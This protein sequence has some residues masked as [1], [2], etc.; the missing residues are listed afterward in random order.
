MNVEPEAKPI[1]CLVWDLD[2][3]VWHGILLEGSVEL[4]PDA[5][6]V[7]RTLDGRGIL[8]AI[9]SRNDHHMAMAQLATFGLA[10][11]F[12]CPQINW[13]AKSLSVKQISEALNLGMDSF[14]FIDD[15]PFE[16]AEVQH[17]HPEVFCIDANHDLLSL[18]DLPRM[19][20]RFI[21]QE[22]SR[23]RHM[24]QQDLKRRG[25]E[26]SFVGPAEDFLASL[27]MNLKIG[28][29][30]GGDLARLEELT[31]RTSQLN[32][33]G[34][35]YSIDE[36]DELR[37]S[38]DH[39]LL[40]AELDD[41]FG[42]YG[43]IGLALVEALTDRWILK[44]LIVSCRVMSRGVGTVFLR[45]IMRRAQDA[46]VRLQAEFQKTDRNRIMMVTYRFAGF[47]EVTRR[48]E[49]VVLEH[50][51]ETIPEAPSYMTVLDTD[52]GHPKAAVFRRD[53]S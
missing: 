33:T 11:F 38:P 27:G 9:A 17:A 26:E 40:V 49:L 5:A 16:R 35:T 21:S 32:S 10:D 50:E 8:H 20:P 2:D 25:A 15:Q 37:R 14:A 7:I 42:W 31:V 48:D 29:A 24:Y 23:R 44:L 53:K 22:Q 13:Q 12:L 30:E 3:T 45:D 46:G 4:R 34:Y 6:E 28:P 18:L 39:L 47:R 43:K 41:K 36:L 51:L 52:L 19:T 1:K